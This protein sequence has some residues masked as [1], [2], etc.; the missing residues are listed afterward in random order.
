[1][2]YEY[3][4]YYRRKLPHIHSPGSTLFVT[5]RLFGSIP[6][7]VLNKWLAEKSLRMKETLRQETD[8]EFHRRW[9]LQFEEVLHK[10]E[11]GPRWLADERVAK[12]VADSL[13]YRDEKVYSLKAF[14]IMSNHVHGVFRPTLNERSIRELRGAGPIKFLSDDPPLAAIMKSLKGYTA[15]EANKILGRTGSFWEEESYDHEIRDEAEFG[16]VVRY[17]LN[18]P[19]K[20]GLVKHWTDWKWNYRS[21]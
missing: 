12:L 3:K 21:E 11:T 18:N 1:M 4:Q 14:T 9:F 15:H 13:K 17:V 7:A 20:A 5:F 19:V 2:S 6:K 8:I 10:A 16:R